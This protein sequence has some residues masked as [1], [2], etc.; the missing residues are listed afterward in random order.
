MPKC[1]HAHMS[2]RRLRLTC[3]RRALGQ[4]W[5]WQRAWIIYI[6]VCS[7]VFHFP[8]SKTKRR[9]LVGQTLGGK[10]RDFKTLIGTVSRGLLRLGN[11][12]RAPDIEIQ[13]KYE[14][15]SKCKEIFRKL[16]R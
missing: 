8:N 11:K 1:A 15:I 2:F 16:P 9:E 7:V 4:R 12:L 5:V 14:E 10:G 3:E 6:T 13:A